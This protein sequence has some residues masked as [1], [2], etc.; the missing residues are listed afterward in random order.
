VSSWEVWAAG[1]VQIVITYVVSTL[2][3]WAH[4]R[5]PGMFMESTLRNVTQKQPDDETDCDDELLSLL[6]S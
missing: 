5:Y 3:M 6:L 1:G 4:R 2:L